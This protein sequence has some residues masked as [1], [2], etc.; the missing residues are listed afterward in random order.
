MRSNC[1]SLE[2]LAGDGTC[3]SSNPILGIFSGSF[4]CSLTHEIQFFVIYK[5]R[6]GLLF[7]RGE[8]S[9]TIITHLL[10]SLLFLKVFTVSY[11]FIFSVWE[12]AWVCVER[13]SVWRPEK[14]LAGVSSL[15]LH[16]DFMNQSM[17]INIGLSQYYVNSHDL[18]HNI[19]L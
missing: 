16:R 10:Q 12:W 8:Y 6:E 9:H 3:C 1:R 4:W 11:L 5:V 18:C 19:L 14:Q 13:A 7:R 15:L 17:S 2:A